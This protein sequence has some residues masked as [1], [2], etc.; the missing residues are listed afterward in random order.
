MHDARSIEF[1][2]ELGVPTLRCSEPRTYSKNSGP[3]VFNKAQITGA[4][5]CFVLARRP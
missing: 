4:G 3:L 5:G 1:A 2:D